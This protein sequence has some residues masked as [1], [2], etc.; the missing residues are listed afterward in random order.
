MSVTVYIRK[1]D[2]KKLQGGE[3]IRGSLLKY[4]EYELAILVPLEQVGLTDDDNL[5]FV[6]AAASA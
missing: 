1:K 2:I 6:Q 4:W 5:V 3:R